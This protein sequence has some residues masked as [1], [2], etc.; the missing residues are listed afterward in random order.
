MAG[1]NVTFLLSQG[2]TIYTGRTDGQG[3]FNQTGVTLP[4]SSGTVTLEAISVSSSY[5]GLRTVQLAINS[6]IPW[7]LID[8]ISIAAVTDILLGLLFFLRSGSVR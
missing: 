2:N 5:I 6:T 3:W 1:S 8:Y 4:A 7:A